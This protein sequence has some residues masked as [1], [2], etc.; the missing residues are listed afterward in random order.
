MD[1]VG[2]QDVGMDGAAIQVAELVQEPEV[3]TPVAVIPK[4]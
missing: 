3:Y 4:A 2:H 1:V